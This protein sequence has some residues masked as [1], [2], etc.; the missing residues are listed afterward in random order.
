MKKYSH[1]IQIDM[2]DYMAII[3]DNLNYKI[4]VS[5]SMSIVCFLYTG[6]WGLINL[7]YFPPVVLYSH[8]FY[9]YQCGIMSENQISA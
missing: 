6:E 2:L 3:Q 8:L 7:D 5:T 4:Y 9:P 1:E